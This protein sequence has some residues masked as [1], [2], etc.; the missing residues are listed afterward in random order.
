M[1]E[2]YIAGIDIGTT[3]CKMAVYSDKGEYRYLAYRD[4]LAAR[5]AGEHE[6]HAKVIWESVKE[7]IREAAAKY[8]DVRAVG[9]TSFGESFVLLDE[10]DCPIRPVMLYTDPRGCEE[11][12]ELTARFGEKSIAEITGLTPHSMYSLPKVMWIQRHC[13]ED[14]ARTKRIM[15]MEDFTAYMLT[16]NACIDYSLAGRSMAFDIR[17]LVWSRELFEAAGVEQELFS[18]PVP[19]GSVVGTVR[20]ELAAEL[21]MKQD[22][23][24]V[25]VG[26]DQV[27]AAIGAG[28]FEEGC[29]V[30]G[31]GTVECITPIFRGIPQH[32]K[33]REGK[34]AIVPYVVPGTYVTY[35]FGYTGG[36]LISWFLSQAA[37]AEKELAKQMD[38]SVYELLEGQMQEG[39]SGIL[40]LP[41]FAGAAT[42]Y[43]DTGSKGAILGLTLEHNTA[44]LYQAMMEGVAYE[45]CL[46]MEYLTESGIAP[47]YLRATGGG[48]ASDVWMQMKAD[49][50][51][52]PITSLQNKEAGAAGGAIAAGIG[53][54]IF[55]DWKDAAAQMIKE[56][57]TY[58]PRADRNAQYREFYG[59][60][61]KIYAAI[62]TLM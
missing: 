19:G 56:K 59:K 25:V 41:H 45:M 10:K 51:N 38:R 22:T 52:I 26:H 42:P 5:S 55:A 49:I 31:A 30:D 46:N 15:M 47:H 12:S 60:Y 36:A 39:P 11:C 23:K 2:S 57:K 40:V 53:A 62:R 48:A 34:Y 58:E 17:S 8:P 1:A 37:K 61:R 21:G 44:D 13:P 16:G 24:I 6:V 50:L 32:E 7:V 28:V 33:I 54:G 9:I 43:M 18:K 14:Y 3:G 35:A 27:A 20:R 4:Y 29:G